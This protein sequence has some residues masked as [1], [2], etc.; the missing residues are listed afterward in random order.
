MAKWRCHK[1]LQYSHM[2][3]TFIFIV[4]TVCK[5]S[6]LKRTLMISFFVGTWLVYF[7]LGSDILYGAI[8][9]TLLVKIFMDYLTPFV[10]ANLG[11]LSRGYTCY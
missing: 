11:L 6:H 8:S 2:R 10:V 3:D 5:L 7:N 1:T 4:R 9:F